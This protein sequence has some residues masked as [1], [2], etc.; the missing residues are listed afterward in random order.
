ME[1]TETT[2]TP[3]PRENRSK[4]MLATRRHRLGSLPCRFP[5]TDEELRNEV[6]KKNARTS[7]SLQIHLPRFVHRDR[8]NS[9][10]SF[11]S[12]LKESARDNKFSLHCLDDSQPVCRSPPDSS[13]EENEV[14]PVV[15]E[16]NRVS[17]FSLKEANNAR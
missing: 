13:D 4:V 9:D 16:R 7:K 3:V 5:Q 15:A 1:E 6:L 8:S 11:L 12:P 17:Y 14:S 2:E 10:A